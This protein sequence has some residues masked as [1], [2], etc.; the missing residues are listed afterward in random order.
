[1]NINEL[2]KK[3]NLGVRGYYLVA[4]NELRAF[5]IYKTS[6]FQNII[7]PFLF[8][9]FVIEALGQNIGVFYYRGTNIGYPTFALL[10]LMAMNVMGQ[11][12]TAIYRAT[13]DKRYGLMAMKFKNGIKPTIY[14]MGLATYQITS[15]L[16]EVIVLY[17]MFNLFGHRIP[18]GLYILTVLL[19]IVF[20]IFWVSIGASLSIL[21]NNYHKRDRIIT[22]L[23]KPLTFAAPVFFVREYAH[24]VIRFFS[25]INPLTYQLDAM[26][27]VA[28]GEPRWYLLGITIGISIFTVILVSFILRKAKVPLSERM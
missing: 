16:I 15:F 7:S 26:R 12:T 6:I 23:V 19:S 5:F 2:A 22:F 18:I 25:S 10:G 17:V 24:P 14:L 28:Y 1:M 13:V 27:S 20:I 11:L 9:I 21:I 3:S 4:F 8:Y